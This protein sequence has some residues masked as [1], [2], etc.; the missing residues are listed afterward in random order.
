MSWSFRPLVVVSNVR[1]RD[2]VVVDS[3]SATTV[4]ARPTINNWTPIGSIPLLSSSSDATLLVF[5]RSRRRCCCCCGARVVLS[6][7]HPVVR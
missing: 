1:T 6:I 7:P 4:L 5:L 2:R 3:N